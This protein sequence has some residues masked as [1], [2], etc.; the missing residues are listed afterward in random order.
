M[1]HWLGCCFSVAL[2]KPYKQTNPPW[3]SQTPSQGLLGCNRQ[4]LSVIVT[5]IDENLP[6][7][8]QTKHPTKGERETFKMEGPKS[9][10]TKNPPKRVYLILISSNPFL[11][12]N[13]KVPPTPE[14][15]I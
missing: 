10:Q 9:W 7:I 14:L 13:V 8:D 12:D 5:L 2:S 6:I 1:V 11:A 3:S 15:Q 4:D